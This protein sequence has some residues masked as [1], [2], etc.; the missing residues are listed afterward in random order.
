MR[1]PRFVT[2]LVLLII[3]L[4][5]MV[6]FEA[7]RADGGP[8]Q[9]SALQYINTDAVVLNRM[10]ENHGTLVI[11]CPTHGDTLLLAH[12]WTDDMVDTQH[13]LQH[14]QMNAVIIEALL[15]Q[16]DSALSVGEK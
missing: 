12:I 1:D 2:W 11:T 3:L 6:W 14:A 8:H 13:S 15:L 16:L 9:T 4:T 7:T 5:C 10:D